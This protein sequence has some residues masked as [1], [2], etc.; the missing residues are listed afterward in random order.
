V[1]RQQKHCYDD[2]HKYFDVEL[3]VRAGIEEWRWVSVARDEGVEGKEGQEHAIVKDLLGLLL[4]ER[5][6][7][8]NARFLGH[9]HETGR[10]LSTIASSFCGS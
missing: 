1:W 5:K 7:M 9:R 4:P 10:M 6:R 8:R 3:V 2:Q